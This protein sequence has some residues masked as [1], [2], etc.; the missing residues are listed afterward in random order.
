MTAVIS[1]DLLQATRYFNY[2][3]PHYLLNH[4]LL[5]V[6]PNFRGFR[7]YNQF[8]RLIFERRFRSIRHGYLRQVNEVI[9]QTL[10]S[11]NVRGE[12]F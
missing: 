3:Y 9:K 10:D 11:F 1:Q 6:Q 12:V 4:F 7:F 8:V 5:L 2:Q